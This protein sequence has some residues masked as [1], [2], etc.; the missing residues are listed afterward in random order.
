MHN[1]EDAL[2][3]RAVQALSSSNLKVEMLL[4]CLK[5]LLGLPAAVSRSS[6]LDACNETLHSETMMQLLYSERTN[7]SIV[8]HAHFSRV[9]L[10]LGAGQN[11]L[12]SNGKVV[13]VCV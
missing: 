1:T 12:I 13:C 5:T 10:G 4:S 11:A 6:I 2:L 7:S 9:V 8:Q 3:S